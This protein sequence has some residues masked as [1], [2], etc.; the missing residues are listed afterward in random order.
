MNA[1]YCAAHIV[2]AKA[3]RYGWSCEQVA[4][5][6]EAL[7]FSEKQVTRLMEQGVLK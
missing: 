2:I 1:N 6:L 4:L 5:A 3:Y 7:G